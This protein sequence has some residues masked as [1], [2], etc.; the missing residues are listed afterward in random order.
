MGERSNQQGAQWKTIGKEASSRA[1]VWRVVATLVTFVI[2][3]VFTGKIILSLGVGFV[4]IILKMVLY[5][6]HE[7]LWARAR[8]GRRSLTKAQRAERLRHAEKK[9]ANAEAL[10]IPELGGQLG[11]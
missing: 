8:W 6:A 5:Y 7:R 3:Y 2:V 9:E 11:G 10:K 4:E 1:S